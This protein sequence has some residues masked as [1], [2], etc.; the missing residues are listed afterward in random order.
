MFGKKEDT[1]VMEKEEAIVRAV[2]ACDIRETDDGVRVE[3]EV[4][5]CSKEGVNLTLEKNV[6]TISAKPDRE[7]TAG[8]Y[9]SRDESV[10]YERS[11][12]VGRDLDQEKVS[13]KVADGV[14]SVTLPRKES[15]KPRRI[16]IG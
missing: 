7:L 1:A 16:E 8:V 14:L 4:P 2:P 5:G 12:R 3:I 15:E 6:L 13:A 11:F 9:G 10:V